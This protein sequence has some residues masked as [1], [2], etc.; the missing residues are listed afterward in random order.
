MI[1]SRR[2]FLQ[3]LGIGAAAGA[4]VHWPLGDVSKAH[5]FEAAR[6]G[7]RDGIILLNSNENAYGPSP[8][9]ADAIRSATGLV[10]RYTFMKY[11]EVTEHI[12]SFHKVKPEQVLFGCGST[13]LLRVAACASLGKGRQL[14]QAW[15]TFESIQDYAKSLG[16]TVASVPLNQSFAHDLDGMLA[17]TSAPTGLIYICNPNNPTATIT[18]RNDLERFI[19]KLPVSIDVL[20]D[21]AYHHYAG[22]S[23]AYASFIDRPLDDDRVIVTRTLSKVYGLA[24]L[25]LGYAVAAPKMIERMRPFLTKAGL[26]AIAAEVVG[27]ALDD[28]EG[29]KQAVKR[30]RDDR[31]EF[32]N[33][34]MVRMLKPI[35][36]H[37]N[38]LMVNTQH[39]AEEVIEHF[40]KHNI[41][42]GRHFPPMDTF[43]RV[44]L[45]T[46]EEMRA[47]WRTWDMIP[48][49]KNFIHH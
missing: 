31:Q 44:S 25:R 7:Q 5:A 23:E 36:S 21:E 35:D 29:L 6:T 40:R 8:K 41:L 39:P 22:Q 30:N 24:G 1:S 49:S 34:A 16:S 33:Q 43:I 17:R 19:G 15:P 48:W 12:A 47:F 45:G 28:T 10:N 3:A 14:V 18:P 2:N 46:Q 20:I 32:H 38:F 13:E 27:V 4:A 26:N 11:D 37:T 9:V 42:I